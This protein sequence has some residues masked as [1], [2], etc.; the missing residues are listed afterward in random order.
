MKNIAAES[1]AAA[2]TVMIQAAI[3]FL[4][5]SIFT[6]LTFSTLFICFLVSDSVFFMV[7]LAEAPQVP[8]P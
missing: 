1:T 5:A 4:T 3:I 6:Y 8:P 7:S 2:G